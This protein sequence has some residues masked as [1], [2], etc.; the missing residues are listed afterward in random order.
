M[1]GR[2]QKM[3]DQQ[4]VYIPSSALDSFSNAL[5]AERLPDIGTREPYLMVGIDINKNKPQYSAVTVK[6]THFIRGEEK[7]KAFEIKT[8]LQYVK[9]A[10]AQMITFA[11]KPFDGKR[12]LRSWNIKGPKI[13]NGKMTQEKIITGKLV[14]GRNEK[15]VFISVVHWNDKYPQIAFYPGLH[16]HHAVEHSNP[17]D[18]ERSYDFVCSTARGWAETIMGL[19]TTEWSNSLD[20]IYEAMRKAQA[21][22]G[23]GGGNG[24]GYN[25]NNNNNGGGNRSYGNGGGNSGGNGGYT[26]GQGSGYNPNQTVETSTDDSGFNF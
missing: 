13:Q 2:R 10:L 26:G 11:D 25:S 16:D 19:L 18:Q 8:K 7:N 22:N 14:V 24:G 4:N 5:Y 23:G 1:L 20:R 6:A 17:D 9:A 3:S 21:A 15:G 12:E